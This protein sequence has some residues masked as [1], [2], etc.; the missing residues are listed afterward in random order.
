MQRALNSFPCLS[1]LISMCLIEDHTK[2]IPISTA[3][4]TIKDL[5]ESH[6]IH[7]GFSEDSLPQPVTSLLPTHPVLH[8]YQVPWE[9]S[10]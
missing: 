8:D 1:R 2:R 7:P 10:K 3:M 9:N 6:T 5:I 4:R